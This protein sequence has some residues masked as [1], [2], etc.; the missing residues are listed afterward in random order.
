MLRCSSMVF[1]AL[2]LLSGSALAYIDQVYFESSIMEGD[3]LHVFV[4][5]WMQD[6]CWEFLGSSTNTYNE[7][8][9]VYISTI[10]PEDTP[11]GCPLVVIPFEVSESFLSLSRGTYTLRIYE[12]RPPLEPISVDFTV[13]VVGPVGNDTPTWDSIKA[14]Y[15]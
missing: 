8:L 4:E 6:G 3:D 2:F 14:I 13:E 5:G 11:D 1:L 7:M 15:R 12:N 10:Y 9:V